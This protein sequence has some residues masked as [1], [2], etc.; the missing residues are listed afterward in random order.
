MALNIF[1]LI[2]LWSRSK[3]SDGKIG[4]VINNYVFSHNSQA[5]VEVNLT[6]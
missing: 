4:E 1:S 5:A 2:T 3:Q 6:L